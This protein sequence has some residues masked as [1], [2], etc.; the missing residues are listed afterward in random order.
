MISDRLPAYAQASSSLNPNT[1]SA[2]F[3]WP[4]TA[5]TKANTSQA[6]PL[7][8]ADILVRSTC[9]SISTWKLI[10]SLNLVSMDRM[11]TR[12]GLLLEKY[13]GRGEIALD[14]VF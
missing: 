8:V 2:P 6:A 13:P 4:Q 7:I 12:R 14:E 10:F 11:H 1:L 3:T 9:A 5:N